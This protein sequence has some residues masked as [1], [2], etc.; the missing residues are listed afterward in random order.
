MKNFYYL[1]CVDP[2]TLNYGSNYLKCSK[3]E[4]GYGPAW[5]EGYITAYQ[6]N[7][8]SGLTEELF[9]KT[10]EAAMSWN[11]A[12]DTKG[13]YKSSFNNFEC[14]P[15][16][17]KKDNKEYFNPCYA[18]TKDGYKELIDH[19]LV[20]KAHLKNYLAFV[21][22]NKDKIALCIESYSEKEKLFTCKENRRNE[23]K[24]IKI[25]RETLD[26]KLSTLWR[27]KIEEIEYCPLAGCSKE[28]INQKVSNEMKLIVEEFNTN[29]KNI[30][31][32]DQRLH[33][34]VKMIQHVNQL[35]PFI[36]GNIRTCYI[37]LNRLLD[38]YELGKTILTNPNRF[39]MCSIDEL[40]RDIREGQKNYSRLVE[41]CANKKD[42]FVLYT[43]D[44]NE[45]NRVISCEPATM[46]DLTAEQEE[47][48][49]KYVIEKK[50]K[51]CNHTPINEALENKNYSLAFRKACAGAG[52]E[53]IRKMMYEFSSKINFSEQTSKSQLPSDLI[54]I[55]KKMKAKPQEQKDIID[56][57]KAMEIR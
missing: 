35:H 1:L 5:L 52:P 20:N 55:N 17:G 47:N 9:T 18:V 22:S 49:L 30:Q 45:D 19:A 12:Y 42:K 11:K 16:N 21:S 28:S 26:D 46:H 8:D 25:S 15:M 24:E 43:Y 56:Q 48:F 37:V 38:H 2:C 14:Y 40:I 54:A 29:M 36:D 31:R 51:Y 34:I 53:L 10:H 23:Y 32:K 44:P 7:L 6:Y 57:L 4:P 27:S 13:K 50:K 33:A 41:H 39:D 3:K